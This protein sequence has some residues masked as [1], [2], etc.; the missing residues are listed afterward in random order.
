MLAVYTNTVIA[1]IT[2]LMSY[3]MVCL[4]KQCNAAKRT[5]SSQDPSSRDSCL[6]EDLRETL[7]EMYETSKVMSA[8]IEDDDVEEPESKI[9]LLERFTEE[10]QVANRRWADHVEEIELDKKKLVAEKANLVMMIY[11][12]ISVYIIMTV[13]YAC[14]LYMNL[15]RKGM[16]LH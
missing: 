9:A 13:S 3:V 7:R 1:G 8:P 2:I 6:Q 15:L 5:G 10:L 4:S 14:I 11:T 16:D 12:C